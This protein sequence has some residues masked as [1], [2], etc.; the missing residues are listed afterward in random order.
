MNIYQLV[1][2]HIQDDGN[3]ITLTGA[4]RVALLELLKKNNRAERILEIGIEQA[5]PGSEH[6]RG[7]IQGLLFALSL[8]QEGDEI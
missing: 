7:Y 1:L 8:M 2:D 6:T 3:Q 4:G 5:K